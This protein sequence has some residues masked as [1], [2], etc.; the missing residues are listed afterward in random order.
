MA[1][2]TL[3]KISEKTGVSLS[4]VS[5]V[6]NGSREISEETAARVL[7][8]AEEAGY[9][10]ARSERQRNGRRRDGPVI[11][12]VC[13]EL[14][15]SYYAGILH[16]MGEAVRE[17]GGLMTVGVSGF[18]SDEEERQVLY[19]ARQQ[20]VDGIVLVSSRQ[21]DAARYCRVDIPIVYHGA[22]RNGIYC[23]IVE[24]GFGP[25]IYRAVAHLADLG[26]TDIGYIG[27]PLTL[28]KQECF[29][30]AMKRHRLAVRPEY[31]EVSG[32]RF[33][34]AGYSAVRRMAEQGTLPTALVCAYDNIALGAM[35]A[36][37]ELGRRVPEDISLIGM[38]DIAVAASLQVPLTSIRTYIPELCSLTMEML[39]RKIKNKNYTATQQVTV[40]T[41]LVIRASTGPVRQNRPAAAGRPEEA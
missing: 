15:S 4:T 34:A 37:G 2:P 33:E 5:K 9:L 18:R 7:Q 6:I 3:R 30:E 12:V 13:P 28:V 32:H 41:E 39:T 40:H 35:Q 8:A 22:P 21:T 29:M 31:L 27:E 25:S 23:D 26:H 11:A 20:C 19:Y 14:V 24:C 16:R 36:L 1:R 17:I 38:D 10:S